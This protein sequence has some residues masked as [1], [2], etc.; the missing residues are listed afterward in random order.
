MKVRVVIADDELLSRQRLRQF[1]E[2]E[3]RAEL[4]AECVN[5]PEALAVIQEKAPNVVFLDVMM[6]GLNGFGVVEALGHCPQTA[7]VFVTAHE[8]FAVQAF[9]ANA[10]DYLLKPFDQTRFQ[11]AFQRAQERLQRTSNPSLLELLPDTNHGLKPKTPARLL[12]RS[13]DRISV[14]KTS[15]I[16]WICAADNYAE[17]HAGTDSHLVRVTLAALAVQ[18]SDEFIRISRSLLV[19]LSCIKEYQ[20]RPHGDFLLVLHDGTSL[21][22]SRSYRANL[23]A[24]LGK[25]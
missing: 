17:L 5:G 24:L 20:P 13:G 25:S 7:V 8:Q 1:L 9:A 22:G 21:H 10:V 18:L 19:N 6:P 23:K 3:P 16:D 11:I 2:T 14:L 15:A 4:I 12:I